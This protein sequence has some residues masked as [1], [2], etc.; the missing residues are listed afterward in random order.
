MSQLQ[1]AHENIKSQDI[2]VVALELPPPK[3]ML[4]RAHEPLSMRAPQQTVVVRK[5]FLTSFFSKEDA[6]EGNRQGGILG[7]DFLQ[8]ND[9]T[10]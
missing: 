5:G 8:K 7:R 9:F 2:T 4:W 3:K 1:L 6:K 10:E